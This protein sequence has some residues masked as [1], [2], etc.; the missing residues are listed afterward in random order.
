MANRMARRAAVAVVLAFGVAACGSSPTGPGGGGEGVSATIG[1]ESFSGSL[2]TA[3]TY[4]EA[5]NAGG[6]LSF[7]GT[8]ATGA[9]SSRQLNVTVTGI[10]GPGTYNVGHGLTS[11]IVYTEV[12]LTGG[13]ISTATWT[14]TLV[15]GS[16][17]VTITEL[18]AT[19]AVGTFQFTLVPSN[20]KAVGNKSV[21]NGK[22]NVTLQ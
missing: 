17:S 18:T 13:S 7:A 3:A 14:S 16:G 6:V 21:T 15:G 4:T 19:R 9:G 22:F 12:A 2:A 20:D 11:I 10:N 8:A 5:G 1:G